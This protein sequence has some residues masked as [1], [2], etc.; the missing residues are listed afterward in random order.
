MHAYVWVFVSVP[1]YY[2]ACT[3]VHACVRARL[4]P[5]A[6]AH[7]RALDDLPGPSSTGQRGGLGLTPGYILVN[8]PLMV[9]RVVGGLGLREGKGR[10]TR[11]EGWPFC[12]PQHQR[13]GCLHMC[14]SA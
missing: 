6:T 14:L 2:H 13:G 9:M 10:P 11:E 1:V 12:I 4:H 3:C 7:V 5:V 8:W